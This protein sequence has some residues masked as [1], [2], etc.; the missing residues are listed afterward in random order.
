M[1]A[2]I[3]YENM[4]GSNIV[5]N[6]ILKKIQKKVLSILKDSIV[7]SMGPAGSNTLILRGNSYNDLV[8]EYSKDGKK[9]INNIKFKNPIE[10]SIQKE[11]YNITNRVETVVGDGTTS[12]VVLSSIIYDKI[13]EIYDT[14]NNPYELIRIF[15]KVVDDVKDS[16]LSMGR[17]CTLEDIYNITY[18]S[19]NGNAKL[20]NDMKNIY[21]KFGMDVFIDVGVSND[22]NSYIKDYSGLTF[23]VGYSDNAYIN[24]PDGTCRLYNPR[25]YTFGDPIDVPEM[26]GFFDKIINDNIMSRDKSEWIPT[27][28]IA[29]KISRDMAANL[30]RLI[31]MLNRY[32]KENYDQKPPL[33]IITNVFGINENHYDKISELCGCPRILKYI[34]S[35][36]Q[37]ADQEKG[38]APTLDN[39]SDFYGTTDMIES[40]ASHT[41]FINPSK[42]YE[43]DDD[44]NIKIDENGNFILSNTYTSIINYLTAEMNRAIESGEHGGV[45]GQLK[46]EL[47]TLKSNMI[48]FLIGG[49]SISDRD[50]QRDLVE[51]AVLNCRS[52]ARNGVGFGANYQGYLGILKIYYRSI[53]KEDVLYM[54][55]FDI[56]LESYQ[57]IIKLLYS[58]IYD[59][60]T[61]IYKDII[62][63]LLCI[64]M[65][66]LELCNCSICVYDIGRKEFNNKVLTSIMSDVSI[67]DTISKIISLMLTSNQALV[68]DPSINI[69][70]I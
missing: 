42:M 4:I 24:T 1:E 70:T 36:V 50:S 68:Q 3:N 46:R 8:A 25:I 38:I 37:K 5:D 17:E 6:D 2:K 39:I 61:T 28:I 51:D 32:D 30:R 45:V 19:T 62:D 21:D 20:A 27:V 14:F 22:E 65:N 69:Y 40:D 57:D 16:I 44:N 63:K 41:R 60:D 10:M 18:I 43:R 35:D 55:I 26:V 52:A 9:I 7:N 53:E 11:I 59:K 49:I 13:L 34:S 31:T 48:E 15:K 58:T 66:E 67:L 47:N 64:N 33:L 12:A 54:K 29:P 56:L 23:E